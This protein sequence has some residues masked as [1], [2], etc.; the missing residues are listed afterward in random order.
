[1]SKV[2][3]RAAWFQVHKWIGLILAIAII[4]ICATGAALVWDEALDGVLN[5]QRHGDGR[6]ALAPAAYADAA[7]AALAPGERLA[8]LRFPADGEGPV[9]A[10][11]VSKAGLGR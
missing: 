2:A 3:L 8:E 10:S 7:R 6:I 4:P 9:I 5:P 11:A 1:M